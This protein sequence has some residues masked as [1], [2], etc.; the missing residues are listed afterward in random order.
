VARKRRLRG[1]EVALRG[2][3][4]DQMMQD[5][6]TAGYRPWLHVMLILLLYMTSR[7]AFQNGPRKPHNENL[8]RNV[9]FIAYS[10]YKVYLCSRDSY[11]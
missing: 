1:K 11:S 2:L 3:L 8:N 4:S 10:R 6:K 7:R 5:Q 9:T